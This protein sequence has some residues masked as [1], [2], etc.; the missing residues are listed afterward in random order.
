[1]KLS[2]RFI[3]MT[4]AADMV[5]GSMLG[6]FAMPLQAFAAKI[7]DNPEG[8]T[9]EVINEGDEMTNNWGTVN[10]NYGTI[11]NNIGMVNDNNGV[12][13]DNFG[14]VLENC[15]DNIDTTEITEGIGTNHT[16]GNVGTS[17]GNGTG[18]DVGTNFGTVNNALHVGTNYSGGT[19][20][21]SGDC[22]VDI[23]VGTASNVGSV[24]DNYG[25]VE[26]VKRVENDCTSEVTPE[27]LRVIDNATAPV[28]PAAPAEPES[29]PEPEPESEPYYE[30]PR[31]ESEDSAQTSATSVSEFLKNLEKDNDLAKSYNLALSIG[32]VFISPENMQKST[33]YFTIKDVGPVSV[34]NLGANPD[35]SVA[36]IQIMLD[37]GGYFG[38]ISDGKYVIVNFSNPDLR[39]ILISLIGDAAKTAAG[40][41]TDEGKNDVPLRTAEVKAVALGAGVYTDTAMK[42]NSTVTSG[43]FAGGIAGGELKAD[44]V[45][46]M[47]NPTD[48]DY[49]RADAAILPVI[50]Y[51]KKT[52]QEVDIANI[53]AATGADASGVAG[54]RAVVETSTGAATGAD[55]PRVTGVGAV[56][57]TSTVA[58]DATPTKNALYYKIK[59]NEIPL[60]EVSNDGINEIN[61]GA[62]IALA[63]VV[64]PKQARE[65]ARKL[66]SP[67]GMRASGNELYK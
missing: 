54:A 58:G 8:S 29:E 59:D 53:G 43:A 14:T 30:A 16:A 3:A 28:Q 40:T 1:M 9:V 46:S 7:P 60:A 10:T 52:V 35:L 62:F 27:D 42:A 65:Q 64:G 63:F 51:A 2:K 22:R 41:L 48:E 19:V 5:F 24:T 39:A 32:D 11:D 20:N 38:Y 21:G 36:M 6:A 50:G 37:R 49:A 56:V 12:I 55:A 23:N 17:N 45:I 15:S 18:G 66:A 47:G 31:N 67:L 61:W 25:K 57:E 44:N 4:I 34:V 26:N 33:L 13:N